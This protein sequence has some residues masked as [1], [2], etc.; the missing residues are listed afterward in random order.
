MST[1]IPPCTLRST[2]Q[3][4]FGIEPDRRGLAVIEAHLKSSARRH[5][6]AKS[7]DSFACSLRG[8]RQYRFPDHWADQAGATPT[9]IFPGFTPIRQLDCVGLCYAILW[10][11]RTS[12]LLLL[13]LVWTTR[14]IN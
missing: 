3:V 12:F 5:A 14:A 7:G 9:R 6:S 10:R 13:L 2:M 8:H 11:Y 4:Q 1:C